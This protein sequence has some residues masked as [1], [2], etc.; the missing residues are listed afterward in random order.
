[1]G[2]MMLSSRPLLTTR[3]LPY[4]TSTLVPPYFCT[5]AA[6]WVWAPRPKTISVGE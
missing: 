1:M 4:T 3:W 6:T 5:W 2:W